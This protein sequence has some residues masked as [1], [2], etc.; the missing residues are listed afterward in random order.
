MSDLRKAWHLFTLMRSQWKSFKNLSE[1]QNRKLKAVVKYAYENIPLYHT[2]FKEARVRPSEIRTVRDLTKL[3]YTTKSDIQSNFPDGIV[4]RHIDIS[5][6]QTPHTSG[7]TGKPMT[8]AYDEKA[9][10]FQKAVALRPNLSCGQ[11][12]FDKW[13]TFTD[14]RHI[15]KKEWFQNVGLFSPEKFSLFLP[16]EKQIEVLEHLS[17]DVIDTYPSHLYLLAKLAREKGG[18]VFTTSRSFSLRATKP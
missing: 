16:M 9:I 11:R 7:S 18:T 3:P 10:D 4:A 12:L 6:C 8:I 13:I 5:K 14:P 1:L 2:K 15:T 17:P